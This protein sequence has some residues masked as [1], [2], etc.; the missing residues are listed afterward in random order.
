MTRYDGWVGGQDGH[1]N[2]M[3]DQD[4]TDP[5]ISIENH[6]LGEEPDY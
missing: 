1:P 3:D 6:M 2:P 5:I 4:I